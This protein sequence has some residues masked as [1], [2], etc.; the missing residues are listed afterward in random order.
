MSMTMR[1]AAVVAVA[2]FALRPGVLTADDRYAGYY[3]PEPQ[4]TEVYKARA[5]TLPEAGRKQRLAFVTGFTLKQ[6]NLPYAPNLAM[7]AKGDDATK[8]ILV[9]LQDGRLDTP[10][11]A[12]AVLAMLTA[13]A[14]V[15][16]IF[17]EYR[18][19]E[20][21]TFLDLCKMLGFEEVTLSNGKDFAHKI[22]ID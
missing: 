18:V 19:E 6:V 4:S 5:V 22:H 16:P 10:Y 12:R 14:R 1:W 21:F 15:L 2:L 8:L 9:A 20:I 3:Y 13:T 11:R 17:Q 7:F